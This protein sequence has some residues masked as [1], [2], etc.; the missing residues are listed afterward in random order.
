MKPFLFLLAFVLTS[1]WLLAEEA[2]F[3]PRQCIIQCVATTR[4]DAVMQSLATDFNADGLHSIKLLSRRMGVWLV[5]FDTHKSDEQMLAELKKHP[6]IKKAQFNH[7]VASRQTFPNDTSFA[8]Q[9]HLNNTGQ[10]GGVNDAD[11]DMPEAWDTA[12]GGVTALGDSIVIAVVDDGFYLP[13]EDIAFW[14][15]YGEIPGNNIDDDGNGYIDDF[16]GWSAYNSTG[17]LPVASHGTHVSGIAGAI[18]N[19]GLGVCGVNWGAKIMPVGGSSEVESVV[20]EAYGYVLEM[21]SKYNE[22]NGVEGAFVVATNSSFGVNYGNPANYPIWAA[23]YD[24]LGAVGIISA[25]ATMNTNANVDEVGDMPTAC[26]SEFLIAV[27]NTTSQDVKYTGAAYGA[28]SIDL[29]APGTQI[30]STN[31]Y[32]Q[33]SHKTGTSMAS[34]QVAGAVALLYAAAEEDFLTG[35]SQDPAA[36]ALFIKECILQSV[37][38]LP[39]L[40][41]I[42]VTGG[43]LNVNGAVQYL[44]NSPASP[45]RPKALTTLLCY[46]NPARAGSASRQTGVTIAFSLAQVPAEVVVEIYNLRGQKIASIPCQPQR[47]NQEIL[48]NGRD[49]QN[50]SVASGVYFYGLR[51]DGA[52]K[53]LN[54]LVM[55][56]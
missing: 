45:T 54:K 43:R 28:N 39:T 51:A 9:W 10:T 24:S 37:D 56:K 11:M 20:V 14:K 55:I 18:G 7:F 30:Y 49:A 40:D 6:A 19:N 1:F 5:S 35:Y 3:V 44:L 26:T 23:M 47:G 53:S 4:Q 32:N 38:P 34:P 27:T 36:G 2:P 33:Y 13:H 46:P 17:N 16:D 22:T 12:T 15:N 29:G 41:G 42:T 48:W 31:Y 50:R 25:A 8:Q 52:L 21:R